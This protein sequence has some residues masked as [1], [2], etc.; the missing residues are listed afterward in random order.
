VY[1]DDHVWDSKEFD[2]V[3]LPDSKSFLDMR[4]EVR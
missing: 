2:A 4:G 3:P 1:Y